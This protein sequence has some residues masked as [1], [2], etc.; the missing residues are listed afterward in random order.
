MGL[1]RSSAARAAAL[2]GSATA[3]LMF[4]GVGVAGAHSLPTAS[5]LCQKSHCFVVELSP[6]RRS[7]NLS[8]RAV[9]STAVRAPRTAS[10]SL[11]R[12]ASL[13]APTDF[14]WSGATP[15]GTAG[16]QNWSNG[17]NWAGGTA[18]SGAVG[19][20]SFPA[21][22]SPGCTAF[23]PTDVCYGSTNNIAGLGANAL[24]IDDG[25]GYQIGGT[26]I[27]LG[28]GGITAGPSASDTGP[29]GVLKFPITLG[30][31]QT[32]SLT[33]GNTNQQLSLGGGVTGAADAVNVNFNG[34]TFLNV[35]SDAEVG[36]FTATG[37]QGVVALGY[38]G[39]PDSLNGTDGSTVSFSGGAGLAAFL[40]TTGPLSMSGGQI[41]VGEIGMPSGS[42]AVNGGLTLDS[43]S[44]VS[45]SINHSGTTAGTDY[46]QLSA[47]GTVTLGSARLVLL[48]GAFPA[49]GGAEMCPTLQAGDVD[50]LI[51]TTGSLSGTFASVPDGTIVSVSCPSS[52]LAPRARINYTANSVTAT[53]LTNVTS[54]APNAG[55]TAGGNT[56]VITGTFA[57]G[58][59]VS[60]GGTASPSV[61][62]VS[63]G[64]L[65]AVAPPHASGVVDVTV[66][67]G[68]GGTSPATVH[69]LYAYGPPTLS[70]FSPPSGITGS[71]V[72]ING[73][74]LV[75]GTTVKFGTLKSPR[76]TFVSPTQIKAVVPNGAS[77][78][79]ISVTTAA[80]TA[81]SA[82]SYTPTLSITGIS[83]NHGPA[84][85]VV[86][87]T[88]VGFTGTS[89]VAFNG[90][91]SS[92][93]THV[94]STQL[95]ATAPA[96]GTTG[97]ITVSNTTAP[98]GTVHS[99]AYY[100]YAAPTVSSFFPS[101]GITG[102]TVTINGQDFT[103]NATVKF[104]TLS[105]ASVTF[106]STSS[107]K[108]KVPNG[109]VTGTISVTT[110]AGTGTSASSFTPTLS[111]TGFSPGSGPVGTVV[112]I[113]G[114]GFNSHSVVKFN[115]TQ[116]TTVAFVSS[117]QLKATVPAGATTG[118]ITVTNGSAS[119]PTGSV[120]SPT[121][122]TVT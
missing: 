74:N 116:A 54:V 16:A 108:A 89:S 99:A 26:G 32:W 37:S 62:F 80:G 66:T 111:I 24:S 11:L 33:G 21:L 103:P 27:T 29:T 12:A 101:S 70:S 43:T 45:S 93:V 7:S 104:G 6:G 97:Q 109:A 98:T 85:T 76:V 5:M 114:V 71:T 2:F 122:F 38:P 36:P 41:Q 88:G 1:A 100:A 119:F 83:P 30:A 95:Q 31:S 13:P 17:T 18:P 77:T 82:A 102:S 34:Q 79:T 68:G 63:S 35:Q 81:T 105:S 48:G 10:G 106:V 47:T 107:L 60:F 92:T 20:L 86:T 69:D 113:N 65:K 75:P 90:T 15:S 42:L 120:T 25:V 110:P 28:A 53:V 51:T 94:S 91:P 40:G 52:A 3:L 67:A 9:R 96:G 115:G 73:T 78:N 58:A 64:E 39:H 14:T 49:G 8:T 19:T 46:S 59:T 56:V 57:P 22:T 84:T 118:P 121:S 55:S 50:E 23:P 4:G 72:T 44:D 117:T 61:T 87:I 112:Q